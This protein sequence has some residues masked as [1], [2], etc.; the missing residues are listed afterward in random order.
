MLWRAP[1]CW[2]CVLSWRGQLCTLESE[3][4]GSGLVSAALLRCGP[5]LAKMAYWMGLWVRV[6]IGWHG[7]G[8]DVYLELGSCRP[9]G[10]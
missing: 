7:G 1:E 4:V 2:V 9:R 6:T 3:G 10:K 5:V 8:G